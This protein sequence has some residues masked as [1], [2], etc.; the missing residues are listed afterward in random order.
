[1]VSVVI[2]TYNRARFIAKAIA[3]VLDQTYRDFEI[4]VVDDGSTDQT[5]EKLESYGDR[6]ITHSYTPNR[7][8]SYARNRG[9]D[10][11]RGT[12]IAF[13]DSDDFWKPEKLKKQME[14]LENHP[15]YSIVA[16]QCLVNLIDEDLNTIKYLEKNELHHELTYAKIFQRPF[17]MPSSILMKKECFDVVGNFDENRRVLED[18][19]LYLRL[20][21]KYKIGFINE[22]LTVFTRGHEKDR[23]ESLEVRCNRLEVSEKNYNPELIPKRL[24]KKR[25]SSLHAHIGKHYIR[26]GE[27]QK[28]R[29]ALTKALAVDWRNVR[30]IKHYLATIGKSDSW[31]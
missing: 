6:I 4:I 1:M 24:Y 5:Q 13:L 18:I 26:R 30:A 9:I 23:R 14:F 20:A 3:S 16:T 31:M 17:I 8:V 25:I 28:G 12:Y 7:G 27:I 15:E 19:D 21:Q 11:A 29:Q 10:L 22:P 2:P